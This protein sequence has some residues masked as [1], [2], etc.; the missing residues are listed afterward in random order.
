MEGAR[1]FVGAV[2]ERVVFPGRAVKYAVYGNR[3]VR[4]VAGLR[5]MTRGVS[6]GPR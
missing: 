6:L 4:G 5:F 1:G 2:L 3:G